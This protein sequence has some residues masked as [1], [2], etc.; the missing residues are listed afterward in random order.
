LFVVFYFRELLSG[1]A[2]LPIRPANMYNGIVWILLY[3]KWDLVSLYFFHMFVL[4]SLLAWGM[5]NYDRFRVPIRTGLSA[6]VL[7]LVLVSVFPHLNPIAAAYKAFAGR[8]PFGPIPPGLVVGAAGC[9]TGL[10]GGL[11]MLAAARRPL[12]DLSYADRQ[13]DGLASPMLATGMHEVVPVQSVAEQT[14]V[15]RDADTLEGQLATLGFPKV[16]PSD[17]ADETPANEVYGDAAREPNDRANAAISLALV[18]AA[19]GYEFVLMVIALTA[20]LVL[21]ERLLLLV[22]ASF[23]PDQPTAKHPLPVTLWVFASTTVL[24]IFWQGAYQLFSR[25]VLAVSGGL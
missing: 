8:I 25:V 19:L 24:L 11:L 18:G 12:R 14:N 2:N 3:T 6:I 4:V 20:I 1:G 7:V 13:P 10:V 17:S 23:S 5:I 21:A 16:S 22:K 9:I 15:S